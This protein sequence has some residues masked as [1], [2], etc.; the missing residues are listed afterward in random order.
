[1]G[2]FYDEPIATQPA[3]AVPDFDSAV[4]RAHRRFRASRHERDRQSHDRRAL[5]E[6]ILQAYPAALSRKLPDAAHNEPFA[7]H[8]AMAIYQRHGKVD[9]GRRLMP[10]IRLHGQGLTIGQP[11]R[12]AL[13]P[14]LHVLKPLIEQHG[15]K[16]VFATA[17]WVQRAEYA[18]AATY[19]T[20]GIYWRAR[21][22][23][24]I[25]AIDAAVDPAT[26]PPAGYLEVMAGL[27]H[28]EL[29]RPVGWTKSAKGDVYPTFMLVADSNARHA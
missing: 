24:T 5:V 21:V 27:L 20:R 11:S 4:N 18:R 25:A 26:A 19:G 13:P 29:L 10:V 7:A 15:P 28:I 3:L 12:A 14:T 17:A 6:R 1:M 9:A 16:A 23:R 22:A 8:A 2:F